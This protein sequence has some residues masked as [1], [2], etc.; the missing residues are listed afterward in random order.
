[1]M[2]TVNSLKELNRAVNR[3]EQS[4]TLIEPAFTEYKVL[5]SRTPSALEKALNGL[6]AFQDA[7]RAGIKTVVPPIGTIKLFKHAV[8]IK[9]LSQ[10]AEARQ[11]I[12]AHYSNV[13]LNSL[14]AKL[15]K[16]YKVESETKSA[17]E[18]VHK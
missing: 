8:E 12:Q 11:Q 17:V 10:L 6:S 2:T 7:M 9:S 4:I 5:T 15:K 3:E 1:M 14:L 18:F 13:D 16:N